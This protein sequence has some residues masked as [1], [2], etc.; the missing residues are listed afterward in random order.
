MYCKCTMLPKIFVLLYVH[1]LRC[2]VVPIRL[3]IYL[4]YKS[5][6]NTEHYRLY[7]THPV[8]FPCVR[9]PEY[10]EKTHNLPQS[11]DLCSFHMRTGFESQ[12]G[13]KLVTL[14][15][16]SINVHFAR[17]GEAFIVMDSRNARVSRFSKPKGR[18]DCNGKRPLEVKGK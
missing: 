7:L 18:S 8:N 12:L 11:V 16:F 14:R 10:P 3:F 2:F 1:V 9:K 15:P 4:P 13:F 6:F 17:V 5:T